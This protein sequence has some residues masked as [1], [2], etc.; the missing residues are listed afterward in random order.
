MSF[1]W[2]RVLAALRHRWKALVV[3][4]VVTGIGGGAAITALAGAQR[5]DTAVPGFVSY[6]LPDTGGFLFGSVSRPP[7]TPGLPRDSLALAPAERRVVHLPQV[8]A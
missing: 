7:Q 5:T 3:L 2:L 8:A 6:S 1:V 4:A